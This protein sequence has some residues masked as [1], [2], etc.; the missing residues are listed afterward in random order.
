MNKSDLS[1]NSYMLNGPLKKKGYDWWWH[2]FTGYNERTGEEKSFFIEYFTIN[3]GLAKSEPVFSQGRFK[4]SG[5]KPSYVMVKAG[6]WGKDACQLHRF[7]P[8]SE[9]NITCKPLKLEADDCLLTEKHITGSVSVSLE[10]SEEHPEYMSDAGTMK[11][12]LRVNKKIAFNVGYGAG[13]FMRFLNAFEMYWHAEGMNSEY[14]GFVEFNGERY[15]IIPEKS[16]GYADKNWGSDFTSPWVWLGCSNITDF[17]TGRKLTKSALDIGGGRPKVF[18]VPLDDIVL[19]DL[20]YEGKNYEFNFSKFL[21]FSKVSFKVYNREDFLIWHV[22]GVNRN[23]IVKV[24]VK[25]MKSDMLLVNYEAPN[26]KK[27]H[28]ELYNGGNG[29]GMIEIYDTRHGKRKLFKK[30]ILN[31]VGCEYGVYS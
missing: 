11:W 20:I 9:V 14:S 6:C 10:D 7:F 4:D 5:N 22:I 17:E 16:Y 1:R 29:K 31:N 26:G 28:N 27:L 15:N 23:S 13:K 30:L 8:Y 19:M 2:S 18:G 21:K 25:C 3:P 12:D 24:S